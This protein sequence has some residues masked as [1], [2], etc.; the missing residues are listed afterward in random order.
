MRG[1]FLTG[2]LLAVTLTLAACGGT[3]DSTVDVG[4]GPAAGTCLE[5]TPDCDDTGILDDGTEAGPSAGMCAPE[6][7]DCDDTGILGDDPADTDEEGLLADSDDVVPVDGPTDEGAD[8]EAPAHEG[9]SDGATVGTGDGTD[10]EERCLPEA[11]GCDDTPSEDGPTGDQYDSQSA[12]TEAKAL[13]GLSEAELGLDDRSDVRIGRRGE[14]QMALTEDYQLG[15]MTVELDINDMDEW[16][17]TA[18]TVE[19]PDGP[20]TFTRHLS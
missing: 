19:L 5:G 13:L 20:Q 10:G 18:V 8:D 9:A 7:T 17:V 6:M 4:D 2:G 11:T 16:I 1:T 3:T 12:T 14:E 15:R